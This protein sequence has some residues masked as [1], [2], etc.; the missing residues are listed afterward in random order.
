MAVVPSQL[1]I[2][3]CAGFIGSHVLEKFLALP[4]WEIWG[5]DRE[6]RKIESLLGHPR[7]HFFQGDLDTL[8]TLPE[9]IGK[10]DAV[11]NLAALCT[12]ALYNT[13]PLRVIEANFNQPQRVVRECVRQKK[14][15][16]HFSTSEVYGKTAAAVNGREAGPGDSMREDETPLI[17]GPVSRQ[18][19]TYSCAKQL[20]ERVIYAHGRENGLAY[21]IIRPFNFIGPRMDFIPPLDGEG[22][23][24]VLA[25]FMEAL[26]YGRPLPLV[27]GGSNRRVFTCIEDA[28]D[29]ILRMVSQPE[30]AQGQIFNIGHPGNE[31]SIRELAALMIGLY[32]EMTG[33]T[34]CAKTVRAR[35][36]YGEGYDDC[37]R[38]IP[39]ISRARRLLGWEPK[40][41][42]RETLQKTMAAYMEQYGAR[43]ARHA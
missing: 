27:D 40:T 32:A 13:E 34:G 7:L 21:T 8:D 36:F 12:P 6:S 4:G 24:R 2:L 37:D 29:A 31:V 9:I 23:P 5:I 14:W 30:K 18:R 25:C 42:L 10:T 3:G 41:A 1:C 35:D 11:I 15:L 16:I 17:L 19:W 39:D 28:V 43:T 20:L 33:V 38:R 26:L 22:V